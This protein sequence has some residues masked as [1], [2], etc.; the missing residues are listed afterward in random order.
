M[1]RSRVMLGLFGLLLVPGTGHCTSDDSMTISPVPVSGQTITAADESAR[2]AAIESAFEGHSHVSDAE[3]DKSA[4]V[5]NSGNL[6]VASGDATTLTFNTE[7]WDTDT[8]HSTSSN[9]GRLTATTAGKYQ[10]TG[11]VEWAQSGDIGLR[12]L[13]IQL[14]GATI[15][16]TQDCENRPPGDTTVACSITTHYNLSATDYVELIATQR[17]ASS[18]NVLATSNYSPEFAMVKVP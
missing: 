3:L 9:T 15:I 1:W 6:A 16:A 12:R 2:N 14:N 10:I 4:R 17:A 7:R 8:I 5:Y 11:M 18:L 13:Q